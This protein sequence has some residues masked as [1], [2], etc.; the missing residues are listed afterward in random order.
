M[1]HMAV[2]ALQ[3]SARFSPLSLASD[4]SPACRSWNLGQSRGSHHRRCE[5]VWLEP[6]VIEPGAQVGRQ[7]ESEDRSQSPVS[8]ATT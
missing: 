1:V 7:W 3:A 5:S 8:D 2:V 4:C 6:L